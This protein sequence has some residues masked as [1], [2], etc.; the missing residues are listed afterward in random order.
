MVAFWFKLL[1]SMKSIL[2]FIF[3]ALLCIHYPRKKF[4]ATFTYCINGEQEYKI[5]EFLIIGCHIVITVPHPLVKLW[6]YWMNMGINLTLNQ[7]FW[8]G[9]IISNP[10][11]VWHCILGHHQNCFI[12]LNILR[13]K[14][15]KRFHHL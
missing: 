11:F 4:Q 3:G 7:F 14:K 13:N 10:K 1:N 12:T 8:Q 9:K 6:H 2:Y 5:L 15:L